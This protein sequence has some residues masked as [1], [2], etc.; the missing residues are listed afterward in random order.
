MFVGND[1]LFFIGFMEI[2]VEGESILLL[3]VKF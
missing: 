1:S 3:I 2:T